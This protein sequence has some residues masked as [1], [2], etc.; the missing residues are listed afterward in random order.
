MEVGGA[1]WAR[2]LYLYLCENLGLF[3]F[4]YGFLDGFAYVLVY[5]FRL[6]WFFFVFSMVLLTFLCLIQGHV[7]NVIP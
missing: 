7:V 2:L 1:S 3:L 4:F 5:C 6:F